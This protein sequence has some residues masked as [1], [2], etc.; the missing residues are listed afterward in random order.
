MSRDRSLQDPQ[1]DKARFR[2]RLVLAALC[3]LVSLGG[4]VARYYQLQVVEFKRYQLQ[5]D[6]NR[7]QVR[8]LEPARGLIFDRNGVVLAENWPNYGLTIRPELVPDVAV[9]IE[10]LKAKVDISDDDIDGFYQRIARGRGHENIVL[11]P[12]LSDQEIARIAIDNHRLEGVFVDAIPLRHYPYGEIFVHAVGYVGRI[13]QNELARL[14]EKMYANTKYIG[15]TGVERYYESI[16]HGSVGYENVETNARGRVLRV[17]DQQPAVPGM[18]L[19]LYLDQGLQK[20]AFDALDGRRGSVVAIEVKTGGV[21]AMVSTP[22]FDPNL[23]VTGI[24]QKDYSALNQS[25]DLPMFNRSVQGQ[26]PPGS[27]IK[28]QVALA[29]LEAGIV[30]EDTWVRD[31]G[32]YQLPNDE[33]FY[34]DWK[35]RGHGNRVNMHTAIVESCDVYYYDL[36]YKLGI[37]RLHDFLVPFGLGQP[38]GIDMIGE[39]SGLIPS[40]RW[41]KATKRVSW[42]PGETLNAGIGQGYMLATPLQLA[43]ATATLAN[44]GKF[45]APSLVSS[46]DNT[47]MTRDGGR[48]FELNKP[49]HWDA[50]E[51]AMRDVVHSIKGT[52][53]GISRGMQ[54][55]MAGKTGTAQVVSIAQDEEYDSAALLERHRDHALFVAYAP[56][57]APEI[58]IAVVVEN[59]EHGATAAA[60]IARLLAD[61]WLAGR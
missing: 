9:L 57:D 35:K 51:N 40:S 30:T 55:E 52:A 14:D 58:A 53:K 22:A 1:F 20:I 39:R 54:Y 17:L 19:H 13:A 47:P 8:P 61:A 46:V 16:L 5:S 18:D 28:P 31:P 59:G 60:P 12:N 33:R 7:I 3:T 10:R 50:V 21:L 6:Q 49:G 24:S 2:F 32:W 56:I 15:K 41:K 42:Y 4:I 45:I 37:D 38:T 26:Y 44:R 43:V 36:A 34:R 29:G 11:K 48:T 25:K 23:F 27:T